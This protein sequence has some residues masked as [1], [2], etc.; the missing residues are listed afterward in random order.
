MRIGLLALAVGDLLGGLLL[1]VWPG[2]WQEWVHPLAMGTVF[3]PVQRHGAL[4]L[5]R[6]GLTVWAARR[7]DRVRMTAV[8]VAWG[9]EVPGA[10]LLAWRTAGTGPAEVVYGAIALVALA[11]AMGVGR[12]LRRSAPEHRLG[13]AEARI[14]SEED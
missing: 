14:E 2:V 1:T 7:P 6:A 11:I 3:Y 9:L 8:A 5:G 12:W 4:M 13:S 10:L